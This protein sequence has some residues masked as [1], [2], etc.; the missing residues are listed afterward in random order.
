MG[1]FGNYK[2][3]K[4]K[5]EHRCVYCGRK[6]PAGLEVRNYKGRF[7]DFWQNWY[8]CGFCEMVV[9]PE[10]NEY[11]E[12]ISGDEF[13][14]WLNNFGL[15]DVCPNG[16]AAQYRHRHEWDWIDDTTIEVECYKCETKWTIGIPF[17]IIEKQTLIESFER[18]ARSWI[19]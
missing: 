15:I 10:F 13:N 1:D 7:E 17:E 3:V 8:T 11:G 9:E 6:I 2:Y 18:E 14:E 4:T 16:H 12:A 19:R 5:K